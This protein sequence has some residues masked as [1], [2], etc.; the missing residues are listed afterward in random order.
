MLDE[1][2]IRKTIEDLSAK[3]TARGGRG[4]EGLDTIEDLLRF[5]PP[6]Q[7]VRAQMVDLMRDWFAR[8][9][10]TG[11]DQDKHM[12]KRLCE[13]IVAKSRKETP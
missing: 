12:L 5:P 9:K 13:S 4:R 6:D 8:M 10:V 1:A 11:S 7:L 3:R 2:D